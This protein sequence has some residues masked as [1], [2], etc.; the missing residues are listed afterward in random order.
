[1]GHGKAEQ[2]NVLTAPTLE[3]GNSKPAQKG[4]QGREGACPSRNSQGS[5]E[6]SQLIP[7]H[8]RG[9]GH[10][11]P[12]ASATGLQGT[13]R[14]CPRAVSFLG[15]SSALQRCSSVET[16]SLSPCKHMGME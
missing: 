15:F 8:C 14:G 4:W 3:H 5:S 6:V 9:L 2:K 10:Q 1:M 13:G 7:L 12:L 11:H 16:E